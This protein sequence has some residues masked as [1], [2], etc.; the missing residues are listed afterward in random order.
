MRCLFLESGMYVNTQGKLSPCCIYNDPNSDVFVEDLENY[1]GSQ[2][3]LATRDMLDRDIWPSGCYNCKRDEELGVLSLRQQ[4]LVEL[5]IP[6]DQLVIDF[7]LGNLCNSDCVMCFPLSSSR[8]ASR[9]QQ[10]KKNYIMVDASWCE[11]NEFWQKLTEL[12]PKIHRLRFQGGE[13]FLNKKLWK[14]LK[15]KEVN[16]IKHKI[17]LH[18]TTNASY[19]ENSSINVLEDWNR[20]VINASIDATGKNFEWIRHGL[21]WET[22]EKMF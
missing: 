19:L 3:I 18:I 16:Q 8:V 12:L 5:K 13:P 1:L 15:S 2:E 17:N 10:H 7:A 22:V 21:N 6:P 20:L 4:S 11:K 9:L 14:W